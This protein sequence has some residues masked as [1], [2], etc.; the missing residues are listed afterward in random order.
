MDLEL[1][2]REDVREEERKEVREK[3]LAVFVY[4]RLMTN[5]HAERRVFGISE[6]REFLREFGQRISLCLKSG[7]WSIGDIKRRIGNYSADVRGGGHVF[8]VGVFDRRDY[9]QLNDMVDLAVNE[10]ARMTCLFS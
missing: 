5:H 8:C 7:E 1:S 2:E 3:D 4:V 10:E 9:S 6:G